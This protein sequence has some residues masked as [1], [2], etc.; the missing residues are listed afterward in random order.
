MKQN[1]EIAERLYGLRISTGKSVER[2][3]EVTNTSVESY[4]EAE[5]GEC[6]FN[7]TFLFRC[8]KEFGVNVSEI[9]SGE[10]EKLQN[11]QVTRTGEGL[12]LERQREFKYQHL[13]SMLMHKGCEPFKVTA[14]YSEREE[15][16]EIHLTAHS[17]EEMDYVLSGTLKV[18]VGD[19]TEVLNAG[20]CIYY[21]SSHPHGM[22]AVGGT[23]CEFLAIVMNDH[24]ADV[25]S[26]DV[27][28]E[29]ELPLHKTAEKTVSDRYVHPV[30]DGEGHLKSVSF[31]VP[32]NF[33]FA[34]DIVDEI[35]RKSPDKLAMLWLSKDDEEKR[36][37]FKDISEMSNRAA[38]YFMSLGIKRGDKVMLVLKRHYQFW[39]S[40]IALNKIGAVAVPATHQ[41]KTH[42]FEYRF[43]AGNID[44]IV[45]TS[46]DDV[47]EV[48]DSAVG[49][50]ALIK[51]LVNGS[52]EGW[53][54][55]NAEIMNFSPTLKRMPT[56]KTDSMLMFFTS[57][58]T[59]YPRLAS[60]NFTY[61]LGH[62]VTARY[63]QHVH[64]EGLHFTISDTGWGK[65]LWGKLY[66]QWLNE[67]AIF[68]YDFD[69][70]HADKILPLFAK[71]NITSFCA[72]PTMY[73]FFIKEDL[74]KYDLSSIKN[75]TIAG[76]ALNPEVFQQFYNATGLKL[77]EGFGQTE[78]TLVLGN[79]VGM[80][81]KP[82]S[83]GKPNPQFA[84]DLM[85]DDGKLAKVGEI[86]EI[87]INTEK[88]AP[89]GLFKGY[90]NDDAHNAEA[91]HDNWY[92]TGDLAWK[93]EDGYYWYV[94]RGDDII[95][96]S[97]YRIGPFEIES[98]IMELPYV[99]ECAVTSVPDPVRGQVVKATIVLTNGTVGTDQR[100]EEIQKYVKEKTAP[101]KYPRVV[102]FV[103]S[104]PKTISGKIRRKAIK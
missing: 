79:F 83:M 22:V 57:G 81:P 86:G 17:G 35:A 88:G 104:L 94:G 64:P 98:V 76:E 50:G 14:K 19:H 56:C 36:F 6:D 20:D 42:D 5:S 74:S 73:R 103:D 60:H 28:E 38:N 99:L 54:E 23:D 101:Y 44:G 67:A 53:H 46:N 31:T 10:A 2:M 95:K 92:H 32:D 47:P 102:E 43:K 27:V 65:A 90:Y 13:A 84:V 59:G 11:Y 12:T 71:Y 62:Y 85:N 24:Q 3:A 61:S 34:Y 91:W 82:G 87:V 39:F 100:K 52:R 70:F 93:D 80:E 78:T 51:I 69:R 58:T 29:S 9:I 96:S 7:F 45:A 37:T 48:V 89:V 40:I 4:M 33:N 25:D 8:A 26:Y 1:K 41:L 97:G 63:W 15:N 72:P 18:Q 30:E 55:F 16:G 75:A 77:M 21:N 66:G 49:S 68:T